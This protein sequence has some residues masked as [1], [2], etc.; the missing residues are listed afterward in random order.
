MEDGAASA[1]NALAEV[2][3]E[4]GRAIEKVLAALGDA[5]KRSAKKG[6][7]DVV[8]DR[9]SEIVTTVRQLDQRLASLKPVARRYDVLI[10]AS[11][12]SNFFHGI[13]SGDVIAGGGVFVATFA[14]LP[15]LGAAVI[16]GIELPGGAHFDVDGAVAWVQDGLAGDAS[17]GFGVQLTGVS[18]RGRQLIHE[19]VQHRE[20]M[21]RD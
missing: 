2:M 18:D 17:T 21:L 16:L 8:D 10:D 14:K 20:P 19:F 13:D 9:I 5:P 1:A 12:A 4:H 6:S 7:G 11:S 15:P 3:R